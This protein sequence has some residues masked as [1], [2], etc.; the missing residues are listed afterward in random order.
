M[1]TFS[2]IAPKSP[3][4]RPAVMV[5]DDE[6]P[7][8]GMIC[9]LTGGPFAW[10]R[11]K[12]EIASKMTLDARAD[13]AKGCERLARAILVEYFPRGSTKVTRYFQRFKHRHVLAWATADGWQIDDEQVMQALLDIDEDARETAGGVDQAMREPG[14]VGA[15]GGMIG[16]ARISP[17]EV[18]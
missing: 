13:H 9:P 7:A 17:I 16:G 10:G 14:P 4:G 5:H 6:K 18:K 8:R 3:T 2:G 15:E 12:L 1:K 11:L